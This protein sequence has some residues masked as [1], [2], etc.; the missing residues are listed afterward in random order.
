MGLTVGMGRSALV[1]LC[2]EIVLDV[3][4][5]NRVFTGRV[6]SVIDDTIVGAVR[7]IQYVLK[8]W[9]VGMALLLS[10]MGTD[11]FSYFFKL[12]TLPKHLYDIVC[13]AIP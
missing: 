9:S 12:L 2:P 5:A 13:E 11:N 3:Q 6:E 1:T 4:D 8:W 10:I 7:P